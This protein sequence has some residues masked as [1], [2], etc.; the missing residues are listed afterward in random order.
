ME[1]KVKVV[2]GEKFY[3]LGKRKEDNK[4]IWLQN[5]NFDCGWYWGIGYIEIFNNKNEIIEHTH[6]DTLFFNNKKCC[7]DLFKEYFIETTLEDKEI[8]QLLEIMETIYTMRKY[9]DMLYMGGSHITEN[10]EKDIIK[11]D[12]EY[13]RIN[14]ILI[15]KLLEDIYT[16]LSKN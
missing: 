6:F 8:W 4:N 2:N 3:L 1:K 12:T 5:A 10:V 7:Y 9:S 14:D 16:L 11:N 15:P 13:K